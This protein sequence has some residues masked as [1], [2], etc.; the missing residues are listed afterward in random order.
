MH[1]KKE[2]HMSISQIPQKYRDAHKASFQ[3]KRLVMRSKLCGC[4]YCGRVYPASEVE[5]WSHDREDMT[6][7]C[8]YCLIDSVIPDASGFSLDAE[9]LRDM[10]RYWF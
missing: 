1:Q 3:N 10:Q 4:F 7:I 2:R 5:S 8:P 6:A 9:F